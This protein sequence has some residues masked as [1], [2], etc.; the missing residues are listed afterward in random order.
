MKL[1]SN[2]L[3]S[4]K[5]GLIPTALCRRR[6]FRHEVL[7]RLNA[8]VGI[9]DYDQI[10]LTGHDRDVDAGFERG[11]S[12]RNKSFHFWT[13]RSCCR[14]SLGC[15]LFYVSCRENMNCISPIVSANP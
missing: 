6:R 4:L 14:D 7:S 8:Y 2:P 1:L 15:I 11:D 9:L 5:D 3:N 10:Q 13:V 12:Q